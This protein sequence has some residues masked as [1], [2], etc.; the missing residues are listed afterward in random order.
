M[1]SQHKNPMVKLKDRHQEF[2]SMTLMNI[3]SRMLE[4]PIDIQWFH[5]MKIWLYQQV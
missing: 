1:I 3:G 5:M 4:E 2:T